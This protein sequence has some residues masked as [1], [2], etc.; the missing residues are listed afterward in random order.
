MYFTRSIKR[1]IQRNFVRINSLNV[2][3][4]RETRQTGQPTRGAYKAFLARHINR[5]DMGALFIAHRYLRDFSKSLR[6][7]AADMNINKE[8]LDA[9]HP[10]FQLMNVSASMMVDDVSKSTDIK[11][12]NFIYDKLHVDPVRYIQ[13]LRE[14]FEE[15][16]YENLG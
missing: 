4:L 13:V 2:K 7:M 14:K 16:R 3:F 12:L 10:Q 6:F 1:R 15:F 9:L 11:K 5:F 8:K